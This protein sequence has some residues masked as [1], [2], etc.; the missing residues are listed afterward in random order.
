MV[1]IGFYQSVERA[2]EAISFMF[3]RGFVL[4]IP[5]FIALPHLIGVN[6]LWLAVPLSEALTFVV[7]VVWSKQRLIFG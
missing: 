7:L 4:V 5:I 3:L 6:G 2:S 1:I